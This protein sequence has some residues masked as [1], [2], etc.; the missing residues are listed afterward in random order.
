MY[1]YIDGGWRCYCGALWTGHRRTLIRWLTIWLS[2]ICLTICCKSYQHLD[3]ELVKDDHWYNTNFVDKK[4]VSNLRKSR[5]AIVRVLVV[6][7]IDSMNQRESGT[8]S[9]QTG[10]ELRTR[11]KFL[12]INVIDIP[13]RYRHARSQWGNTHF[14]IGS[15]HQPKCK[16]VW[17][18]EV[19][20]VSKDLYCNLRM[21]QRAAWLD[22]I[23]RG[24]SRKCTEEAEVPSIFTR[25][26]DSSLS[27]AA[28]LSIADNHQNTKAYTLYSRWICLHSPCISPHILLWDDLVLFRGD[29]PPHIPQPL[30]PLRSAR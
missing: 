26:S 19:I 10:R 16:R 20:I 2:V 4:H 7:R 21:P 13:S 6:I 17:T 3:N 11:T 12:L 14:L 5:R 18:Q 8:C 29:R 23:H 9:L 28:S 22:H 15:S 24:W 30:Q 27:T 1:T 25:A